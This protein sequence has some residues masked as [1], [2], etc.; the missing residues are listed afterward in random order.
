MVETDPKQLSR[1]SQIPAKPAE[2]LALNSDG[3]AFFAG[4][5]YVPRRQRGPAWTILGS[6]K[7][8]HRP[9]QKHLQS[10]DRIAD[11]QTLA[12]CHLY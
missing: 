6:E 2:N 7:N 3:T 9:S 11:G 12:V 5:A 1:V 8:A 10:A 4:G